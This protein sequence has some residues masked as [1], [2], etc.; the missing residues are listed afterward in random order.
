MTF[1][2]KR[3]FWKID[4]FSGLVKDSIVTVFIIFSYSHE[5][6]S[7]IYIHCH[8]AL[9]DHCD[10]FKPRLSLLTVPTEP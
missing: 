3:N 7:Y 10:F 9:H 2:F 4:P 5:F 8:K 1:S 6:R